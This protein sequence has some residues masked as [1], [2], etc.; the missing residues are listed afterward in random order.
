MLILGRVMLSKGYLG[1]EPPGGNIK[2]NKHHPIF[3]HPRSSIVKGSAPD[4]IFFY[5][6]ETRDCSVHAHPIVQ[7]NLYKPHHN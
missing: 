5:S 6:K 7:S 1:L 4:P 3:N 2:G